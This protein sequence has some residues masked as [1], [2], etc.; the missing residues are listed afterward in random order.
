M[1]TDAAKIIE[2][3]IET[4]KKFGV[5]YTPSNVSQILSRWAVRSQTDTVLEPSFGGCGFLEAVRDRFMD[6]GATSPIKKLCGCDND[7]VAFQHLSQK[8]SPHEK[9]RHFLFGDFLSFWPHDFPW[10]KFDAVIGNPP[11]VSLHNMSSD[12]RQEALKAMRV[13]GFLLDK[14]A[15]LWA[16]FVLHALNFIRVGGRVAWLLPGSFLHAEYAQ[17]LRKIIEDNFYRVLLLSLG[18]RLFLQEGTD[19]STVI[20]LA[21]GWKKGPAKY[22][23]EFEFLPSIEN[24][25]AIVSDWPS[26]FKTGSQLEERS[27]YSL[28]PE[29]VRVQLKELYRHPEVKR[30]GDIAKVSIGIVTGAN[31]FFI[32]DKERA[33][34]HNIP[35]K[36]LRPIFTKFQHTAGVQLK[37]NALESLVENGE[38]CLLL[39]TE[40][41]NA[42]IE[43][44]RRYLDSFP[45]GQKNQIATFKKR[46]I[47]HQ[48]DDGRSPD[49]FLSY[50]NNFGPR[51]VLNTAKSTST[52]SVHRVYFKQRPPK[53]R[54]KLA[55]ISLLT[56]F[57]QLSAEIEGR[58]YGSGVLK[59]ELKE[60][61]NIAL[62][63]PQALPLK[64]TNKIFTEIDKLLRSGKPEHARHLA[65]EFIF[66]GLADEFDF[67][68]ITTMTNTLD[69][70]RRIR[71]GARRIK[72]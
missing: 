40:G 22:A 5:F 38:R 47:W 66:G 24:L 29:D 60:A 46:Q 26:A 41:E 25:G 20:L 53:Y 43:T 4:K 19:E 69:K 58:C 72:R 36:A 1:E 62:L 13:G 52:N 11:Y 3:N 67:S 39:D 61:Q 31:H 28:L 59:H 65:D 27:T 18:E 30:I 35:V 15:S 45:E 55:A 51:L 56:T 42:K 57:S 68:T 70:L 64:D 21:D 33:T 37:I 8:I 48:P 63:M 17:K 44:V 49:A 71:R 34:R 16:Y 2:T 9:N 10:Q 6:L 23:I 54:Q 14:K 12:Q 7:P 50:M 32:L